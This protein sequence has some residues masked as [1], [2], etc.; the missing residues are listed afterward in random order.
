MWCS[1]FYAI[2]IDLKHI[3]GGGLNSEALMKTPGVKKKKDFFICSNMRLS[4]KSTQNCIR[5]NVT[6]VCKDA[7]KM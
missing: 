2:H 5:E 1:P 3:V 4:I 7:E 6:H